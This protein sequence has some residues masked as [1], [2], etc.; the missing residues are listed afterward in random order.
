MRTP[1]FRTLGVFAGGNLFVAVLGGLAGLIQARWIAP[2][3]AGEF[4][5]FGILTAYLNIGLVLVHDGLSRQFPYLLGQGSSTA[6]LKVAA[7]A[8]WWYL[9]LC[10]VFSLLFA[11]L[12]LGSVTQGN[13]RSAV[14]WGAQIPIVWVAIY[15]AYLG[16]MYR[17]S[18]D[19]KRLSYNGI[20]TSVFGF[21]ALVVVRLWGY[22]GLAARAVLGST[23]GL[24]LSRHYV[25]VKA[26]AA[27]DGEGLVALARISLPLSIP[28]YIGTSGLSASLSFIVLAYC[29]ESGL[30]IYGLALT[31]QAMA[32][33]LTAAIH[34]MFITKMTYKFGETGD[35]GACLQW[36][37]R[38]TLLSMVAATVLAA[39]LGVAIGPFVRIVL[40]Q[41][42]AAIPVIRILALQLPLSAAA[43]P[44]I[45][46]RSALWY[47]SVVALSL[48][49][50]LVCLTAVAVLPKTLGVIAACMVLGDF[51]ALIVGFGILR[52]KRLTSPLNNQ[53]VLT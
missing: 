52:G 43:L 11:G 32:M 6:A 22:W 30:G 18:F 47:K 16:V 10:W 25:P 33:T 28:G 31:F 41:Y 21:G 37:K 15:G 29:G 42:V 38:P 49:P 36:A 23:V 24:Y 45:I 53:A 46:L 14:G 26:K 35:V 3:I 44:L 7:T 51:A 13:W 48:T 40:P 1:S 20:M 50:F 27:L 34:Q 8:K 5:K 17:T 19:F 39:V 12:A 2:G 4:R 9:L